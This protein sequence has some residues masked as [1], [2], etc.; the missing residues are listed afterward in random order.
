MPVSCWFQILLDSTAYD[1]D[2]QGQSSDESEQVHFTFI[3][4]LL[5]VEL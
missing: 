3:Y 5:I 4:S 1:K 2:G